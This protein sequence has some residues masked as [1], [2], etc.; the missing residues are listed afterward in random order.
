MSVVADRV[1]LS[2]ANRAALKADVVRAVQDVEYTG[3]MESAPALTVTI[4]DPDDDLLRSHLM[5][6]RAQRSR[7]YGSPIAYTL[8]AIDLTFRGI[9]YR[10]TDANREDDF[11]DLVFEHRGV[12]Y[13]RQ[14]DRPISASRNATT[15]ALFIRRQVREVG[16][17][18][19][20]SH[21]MAFWAPELRIRQPIA[22]ADTDELSVNAES[23][24]DVSSDDASA[25]RGVKIKGQAA[26]AEQ[27]RN[28]ALA[29]GEVADEN[30]P[31]KA[32]VAMALAP[33]GENSWRSGKNAQGSGATGPFQVMP[34]TARDHGVS[35]DD[36]GVH[37]RIFLVGAKSGRYKG[38]S[39]TGGAPAATI[40]R[41]N[42]GISAAEIVDRVE[43][44]GAGAAFYAPY[45]REAEAIVEAAGGVSGGGG[46]GDTY[47]KQYRFRR[48]KGEDGWESTGRLAEE[49]N[50]RRFVTV[51]APR[52]DVFIYAADADL[53]KF[54]PQAVVG[55]DH[56]ALV[57]YGY[58]L[59]MGR[60]ARRLSLELAPGDLDLAWGLPIQFEGERGAGGKWLVWEVSEGSDSATIQVECVQPT[61][62][63]LEPASERIQRR[64]DDVEADGSRLEG[65]D[66]RT[67]TPK[68]IIDTYVLPVA[69]ENGLKTPSGTELTASNNDAANRAH[70]HLGSASDHAGPSEVKWASDM[71]NGSSPTPEMDKVAKTLA[72]MFDIPWS[73]A[74]L[75]SAS[76]H[77]CRFQIIY[78]YSDAQAGN[79]YNHIHFGVKVEGAA[80]SPHSTSRRPDARRGDSTNPIP[81]GPEP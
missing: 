36:F 60:T 64:P 38:K 31:H 19:K 74:G 65:G 11:V 16:R 18:R 46:G 14:H 1:L 15:R 49:V 37:A 47:V 53:M 7:D 17:D 22:A 40:A 39:F 26:D 21:R 20:A 51:V 77:G 55:P 12:A 24:R 81:I 52:Q 25:F 57:D 30:V 59:T 9:P 70:T 68:E 42:P 34:A 45:I 75:K 58:D 62:V 32:L 72:T 8:R 29:F 69:R 28:L 41:E 76:H 63:K 73:G 23:S 56:P 10:L 35:L 71:S 3:S 6:R 2:V 78:R 48:D 4:L 61:P 13:M 80:R 27:R 5:V 44:G 43:G 50:R 33:I 66:L 67:M 79:H 54:R